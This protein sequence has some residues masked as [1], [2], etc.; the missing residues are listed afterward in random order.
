M[1]NATR[2]LS[3]ASGALSLCYGALIGARDS[4][5]DGPDERKFCRD[6]CKQPLVSVVILDSSTCSSVVPYFRS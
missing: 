5:T 4:A 1:V 6:I 2:D 3:L